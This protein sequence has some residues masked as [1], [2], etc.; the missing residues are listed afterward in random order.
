MQSSSTSGQ[1][2]VTVEWITSDEL[3]DYRTAEAWME[4]RADAIAKGE[5]GE[6][7][8][9]RDDVR[10]FGAIFQ[11]TFTGLECLLHRHLVK[12]NSQKRRDCIR[13]APPSFHLISHRFCDW[14]CIG[15]LWSAEPH[16]ACVSNLSTAAS[17]V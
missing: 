5:V 16:S 10:R 15:V 11:E 14:L 17:P 12:R 3:V 9:R 1:N 2:N 13:F 4:A 8:I 7:D 6:I